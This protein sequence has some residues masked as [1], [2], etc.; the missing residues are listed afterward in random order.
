MSNS[1]ESHFT[2]LIFVTLG[3]EMQKEVLGPPIIIEIVVKN[4]LVIVVNL[5]NTH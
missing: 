2:K 3:S 5:T 4:V 1:P